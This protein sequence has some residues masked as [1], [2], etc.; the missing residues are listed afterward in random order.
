[1][2][3]ERLAALRRAFDTTMRDRDFQED[4]RRNGLEAEGPITGA[5]VDDMLRD[6]YATPKAIVQRYEAI[7]NER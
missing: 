4:A 2:P 5:E 6:I 3:P 7:R 1:V